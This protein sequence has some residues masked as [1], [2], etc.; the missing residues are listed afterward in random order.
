MTPRQ[1][2]RRAVQSCWPRVAEVTASTSDEL[3]RRSQTSWFILPARSL[4]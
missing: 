3:S 1:I 4:D 2:S